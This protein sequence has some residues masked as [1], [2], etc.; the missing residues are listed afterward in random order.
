LQA[1][2]RF[3][4]AKKIRKSRKGVDGGLAVLIAFRHFGGFGHV[5]V[6][7]G[8]LFGGHSVHFELGHFH[9]YF[10]DLHWEENKKEL[11]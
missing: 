9:V 3:L 8:G 7:I 6:G 2:Y 1:N 5:S 10:T 11:V 4:A